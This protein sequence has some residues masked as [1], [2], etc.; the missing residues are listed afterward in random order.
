MDYLCSPL[1]LEQIKILDPKIGFAGALKRIIDDHFPLHLSAAVQHYQYY[2]SVQY[3][4]QKEIQRLKKKEYR[5]M[6]KA[7][8]ELSGLEN[9]NILGRLIPHKT[10]ILNDLAINRYESGHLL[11]LL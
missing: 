7:I 11:S 8:G 3:K 2:K 1:T 6:E 4:S 10:E 9:A 5:Y